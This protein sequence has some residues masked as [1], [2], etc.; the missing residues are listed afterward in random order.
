MD[1]NNLYGYAM[2]KFLPTSGFKWIN[3][4]EFDLNK[5]TSNS[6]KEYVLEFDLEFP[7]ELHRLYNGYALGPDKIEIKGEILSE[8]QLKTAIHTIFL[9]ISNVKKVVPN[10]LDK[11][12]Y[13]IHHENLQLY[14]KLGLKL[15]TMVKTI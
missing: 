12:N 1:A 11:E 4:N 6:S 5:Y 2:Y 14:L 7:E 9:P 13:V 10:L 3:P 15:I 8:Y